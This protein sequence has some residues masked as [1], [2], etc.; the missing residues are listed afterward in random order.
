MFIARSFLPTNTYTY[1]AQGRPVTAGGI[2]AVYDAFT[3][4]VEVQSGGGNTQIVYA[5]DGFKFAYMNGQTVKRYLAPLGAGIQ[6]VYTSGT[7][8]APAYWL[9]SD[10]LGSSRIASTTAQGMFG[11]QAY[12][13][14]GETYDS[15]G[16]ALNVFT[17][18]TGDMGAGAG[19]SPIYDFLFRQY[20]PTQGRWTVPDPL[21][22]GR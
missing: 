6:V 12:A 22:W 4:L 11:D 19:T 16:N 8:A 9:H 5:P 14:F 13:P 2:T 17:G 3:R 1:N 18:Q 21:A 20:S 7:P 15:S 10:W